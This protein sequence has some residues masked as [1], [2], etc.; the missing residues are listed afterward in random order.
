MRERSRSPSRGG[1]PAA[2]QKTR[3]A[4]H[5]GPPI[6]EFERTP[7][8]NADSDC[9][10]PRHTA[11]QSVPELHVF[12][13]SPL[14][15]RLPQIDVHAELAVISEALRRAQ[16]HVPVHV[17]IASS[18]A[19]A[20]LLTIA[21]SG[22]NRLIILHLC[23]HVV[24]T[25]DQ[26]TGLVLENGHGGLH[27]LYR[28]QLEELL[29]GGR[30]LEGLP[31]VVL[32]SCWSE[33]LA[34]LFVE[35]GCRHVIATRGQVPD[36]AARAFTH[37]FYFALGSQQS[38]LASWE[39]AQQVLRHDPNPRLLASADLFVLFGQRNARSVTLHGLR[40]EDGSPY[41]SSPSS[42][43]QNSVPVEFPQES[44]DLPP[45]VE[46]FVGRSSVLCEILSHFDVS[47]GGPG[48]RVCVVTGPEGIGKS[49]VA[50][51]LAHFASSPGRMFSRCIFFAKIVKGSEALVALADCVRSAALPQDPVPPEAGTG[52]VPTEQAVRSQLQRAFAHYERQGNRP[53][54]VIDD[55]AGVTGASPKAWHTLG[56]LLDATQRLCILL[57]SRRRIYESLGNFKC[58]NVQLG[59]LSNLEVAQL[60]L[61]RI[62]RPLLP[63][64]LKRGSPGAKAISGTSEVLA[65]LAAHPLLGGLG[66][67]PRLV[68]AMSQR[69]TP[70][71]ESLF[72]L[73]GTA[74]G[75]PASEKLVR[76]S[77]PR[78]DMAVDGAADC[79]SAR[80][81]MVS[82]SPPL[83]AMSV[84][85]TPVQASG[86]LRAMSIDETS[87]AGFD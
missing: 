22:S 87:C 71:V 34:E 53:L 23:A 5:H 24:K 26:G 28:S 85:E 79:L 36:S 32:N 31:V 81:K 40:P 41:D 67:N 70:E 72:D 33:G 61:K 86:I 10:T 29:A 65:E 39:S 63:R 18:R 27:V 82:R 13:A 45:R 4:A 58:V 68:R 12:Y 69:V 51:E 46:D 8:S 19:L 2:A 30:Q 14:D 25:P 47:G 76:E 59:A 54:L 60:F 48:R 1:S 77:P 80:E 3:S 44:C 55:A 75:V 74:V 6:G 21:R 20:Q 42:R 64:D 37:Q 73:C 56:A 35:S 16:C 84:D 49:A 9:G 78:R 11:A 43:A 38:V 62:H 83:R 52:P 50:T 66:G 15:A 17:S 57:F 7:V